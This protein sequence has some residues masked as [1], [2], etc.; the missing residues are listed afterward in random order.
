MYALPPS[1]AYFMHRPNPDSLNRPTALKASLAHAILLSFGL[2]LLLFRRG[3]EGE[4]GSL[5]IDARE[6]CP[7]SL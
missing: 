7:L 6:S 3:G 4:G 1:L 2:L 5:L